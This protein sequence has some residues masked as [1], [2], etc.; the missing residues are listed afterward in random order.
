M[1]RALSLLGLL[2]LLAAMALLAWRGLAWEMDQP[3]AA[4]APLRIAVA[5]GASLRGTLLAIQQQ[6]ALR[7]ARLVELYLRLHGRCVRSAEGGYFSSRWARLDA[8]GSAVEADA[9]VVD[10]CPVDDYGAF[11]D[12]G[13]ADVA[14]VIDG[15]V[16]GEVVA[17][18]VAALIADSDV[19]EAV[20]DAAIEA[21]IAAPVAV[22]EAVAST[23]ET[24]ISGRPQSALI[25]RLSPCS[26]NPVIAG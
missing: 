16:V 11:V 23:D 19:A 24:P 12:V 9:I 20:V 2:V 4:S 22:I 14:D 5:P 7:H 10:D 17:V 8:V 18:P 25:R 6:G 1:R 21:D 26:G 13:D 3:S 15:A